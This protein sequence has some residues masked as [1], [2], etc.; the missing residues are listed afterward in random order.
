MS[1]N[2][3]ILGDNLKKLAKQANTVNSLVRQINAVNPLSKAIENLKPIF[4]TV[5]SIK[6]TFLVTE[7]LSSQLTKINSPFFDFLNSYKINI[8]KIPIIPAVATFEKTF[9]KLKSNPEFN[10]LSIQ[11]ELNNALKNDLKIARI[12]EEIRFIGEHIEP[13]LTELNIIDI[14]RGALISLESKN[15]DKLRHCLISM[16]TILEYLIEKLAPQNLFKEQGKKR[17]KKQIEHFTNRI[18]FGILEKF[19]IDDI[20]LVTDCY[21]EL[22]S[23]HCINTPLSSNQTKILLLKTAIIVWLFLDIDRILTN[24]IKY[25]IPCQ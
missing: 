22:C 24:D 10:Y 4:N 15:P 11:N 12:K 18:S 13:M 8:P 14:W 23:V 3:Q 7:K 19:T 5:E 25:E 6:K 21:E 9:K 2:E 20:V 17:R 16:R 1:V